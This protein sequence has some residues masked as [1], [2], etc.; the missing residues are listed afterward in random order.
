MISVI[1]GLDSVFHVPA[2]TEHRTPG[3]VQQVTD[4]ATKAHA[5]RRYDMYD[6]AKLQSLPP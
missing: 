5:D 6:A 3:P 2:M 1:G 4:F